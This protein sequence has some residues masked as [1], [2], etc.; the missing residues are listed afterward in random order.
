MDRQTQY[1]RRDVNTLKTG[2][3]TLLVLNLLT[4]GI[5]GYREFRTYQALRELEK[6]PPFLRATK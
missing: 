2:V 4:L 5:L 6:G 3:L 1:I